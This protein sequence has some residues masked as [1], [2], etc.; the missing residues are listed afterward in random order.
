MLFIKNGKVFTM[1]DGTLDRAS[2][3]I[4]NGKIKE[5][6]VDLVAPLDAEVIDA[7]GSLVFPGFIDAIHI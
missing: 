3:L 1:E 7:E 5:V 4:E 2:I 6:G